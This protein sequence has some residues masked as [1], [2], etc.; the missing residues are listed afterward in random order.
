VDEHLLDDI[1]GVTDEHMEGEHLKCF[2]E[3]FG[4]WLARTSFE[5]KQKILLGNKSKKEY[6]KTAK[7]VSKLKFSAHPC[8]W[9]APV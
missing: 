7:E 6:F 9:D 4:N 2:L 5:T 8:F 3:N 1:D